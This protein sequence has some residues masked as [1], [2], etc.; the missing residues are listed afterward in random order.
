M[1]RVS[2]KLA[3]EN[4]WYVFAKIDINRYRSVS[5]R[6]HRLVAL[7]LLNPPENYPELVVD[8]L[9]SIKSDNRPENLEWVDHM[10]NSD[11]AVDSGSHRGALEVVVKDKKTGEVKEYRS[12]KQMSQLTGF[13]HD[14]LS[15]ARRSPNKT[16]KF[17]YIIKDKGDET[18]WEV[19]E[20]IKTVTRSGPV[21]ARNVLTGEITHYEG[22]ADAQRKTGV[23]RHAIN[24][25][26]KFF[27]VPYILKGYEWK[28]ED[29]NRPWHEFNEYEMEKYRR[30]MH[31]R[32]KVYELVDVLKDE[33]HVCYGWEEASVIT[34]IGH[35]NILK[36][37]QDKIV[38]KGRYK[39]SILC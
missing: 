31:V 24:D 32:S 35:R 12:L 25:Y 9:N 3:K 38:M 33:R 20:V 39:I 1:P 29:D 11:R 36:A 14:T 22:Y 4:K 6:Y 8:H 13:D 17:R 7:A 10:E 28:L 2:E 26:F 23:D 19:Y 18:P 27:T 16:Y 34:G 30:G 15:S 5:R 21:K 37:V